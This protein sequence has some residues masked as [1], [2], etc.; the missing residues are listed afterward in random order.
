MLTE[1]QISFVLLKF[2]CECI[3]DQFLAFDRDSL[4]IWLE[5]LMLELEIELELIQTPPMEM[6]NTVMPSEVVMDS[7]ML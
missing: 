2:D 6:M 3:A 1:N 5:K 4:I 7:L